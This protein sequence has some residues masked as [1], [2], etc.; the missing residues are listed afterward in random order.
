MDRAAQIHGEH[1]G[2]Q[3]DSALP[4][5]E[6]AGAAKSHT[7]AFRAVGVSGGAGNQPPVHREVQEVSL[8]MKILILFDVARPA[9]PNETF[10]AR[11]LKEEDKPTEAD[12]LR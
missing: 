3:A 2:A 6:I 4:G 8:S 1:A 11:S 7:A 10:S 9:D 5:A 12:V